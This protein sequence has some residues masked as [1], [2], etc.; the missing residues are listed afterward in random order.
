MNT[1]IEYALAVSADCFIEEMLTQVDQKNLSPGR[2][3]QWR[4]Q[5]LQW[6]FKH[7]VMLPKYRQFRDGVSVY[8]LVDA[9]SDIVQAGDLVVP[10]S[11]GA[12][13][14]VTMQTFRSRCGV[15]VLNSEG[16]GPM[17]FGIS[18]ALGACVASGGNRT[19]CI[20]GDG[21]FTMNT[22]ELETIRRLQ[23]PIKFFILDNNGYGSIRAT[24]KAYFESRF[25]GSSKEGGL[26]LPNLKAIADAYQIKYLDMGN[27]KDL[28]E[29]LI[30]CLEDQFPCICRVQVSPQQV[31]AP[32]ATSRQTEDGG[33][34]TAPMEKMWPPLP[35]ESGS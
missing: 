6:K 17:G 14:E 12:C 3:E 29:T 25:V 35:G 13:S 31:T 28:E 16:M 23:L 34:E 4:Q 30:T 24:Q 21:G 2:W 11:S 22:Q 1:N 7:P 32:R 15:R 27:N 5:C 8:A 26:T 20:D 9:I 10:G 33:M 19:I 18:G